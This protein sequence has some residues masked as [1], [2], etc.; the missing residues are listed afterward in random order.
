MTSRGITVVVKDP[1]PGFKTCF[2][3]QPGYV[4]VAT[5]FIPFA[6]DIY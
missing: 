4:T 2:H 5:C 3:K 1:V 6:S